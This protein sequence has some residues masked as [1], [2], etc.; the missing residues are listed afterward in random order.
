M[1]E[2]WAAGDR[3]G[4]NAAIPDEVVDDLIVHGSV[5]YC[6]ERVASYKEAGLDTPAIALLPTGEDPLKLVRALAPR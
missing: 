1:H 3:A 5:E 6:R 4:A 2:A